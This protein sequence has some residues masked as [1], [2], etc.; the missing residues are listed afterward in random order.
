MPKVTIIIPI[1]NVKDYLEVSVRSA[2][3]QTEGDIQIILVDDGSTDG[4]GALCDGYAAQDSRIQVIHK[5]NG[6]L[7]SARNAGVGAVKAEYVLLLDGD[8]YL[9][10]QA[11]ERLLAAMDRSP[12]DLIQF[13][14]QEV[15]EQLPL[16]DLAPI[17]VEARAETP[18]EAFDQLYRQGGVCAS[19][20]TKLFRRELLERIPFQPIRHEDEVWCTQAF[21][22]GLTVTYIPDVLYGYVMRPGSIIHSCFNKKRMEI[23]TVKEQRLA[24]LRELELADLEQT[25]WNSLFS[26]LF[27]LYRDAKLAKNKKAQRDLLDYLEASPVLKKA[28]ISGRMKLFYILAKL[29]KKLSLNL[30]YEYWKTKGS[31][32]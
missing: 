7:S 9:H 13:Q 14:W 22:Q 11:V 15:P 29:S 18:R 1:Y 20:C 4:S 8:D 26:T 25:E 10:P 17:A 31:T 6:G 24:A 3:E 2:R 28:H 5:E 27:L 12:A 21:P 32:S 30:Y 23:L 19:G 16:P